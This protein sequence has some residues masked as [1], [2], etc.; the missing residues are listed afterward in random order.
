MVKQEVDGTTSVPYQI[1]IC[2]PKVET[3]NEGKAWNFQDTRVLDSGRAHPNPMG[4]VGLEWNQTG[5]YLA[6]VDTGG[7]IGVWTWEVFQIK[8]STLCFSPV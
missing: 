2:L 1:T 4:I 3:K 8:N 6:S 5:D 7:R